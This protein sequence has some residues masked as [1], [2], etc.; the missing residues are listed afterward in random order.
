MKTSIQILKDRKVKV[1]TQRA[2]IF[3]LLRQENGH[4]TA[5]EI[6]EKARRRF[7][8]VS[9][10][11]IYSSLDILKKNG[12]V[13]EL[14]IIPDKSCFNIRMDLHHHFYCRNCKEIFDIDI[15]LCTTLSKKEAAGHLIEKCQGYFYG[16]CKKC[17]E[18]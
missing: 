3:R 4:L 13:E 2:E 12:L 9:L 16:I 8:T 5:E 1:T 11:T 17:R 15:P 14:S 10:A 6:F 7:P 18:K